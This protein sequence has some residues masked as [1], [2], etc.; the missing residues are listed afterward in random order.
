[1]DVEN[2]IKDIDY[3]CFMIA[4][5][6][7]LIIKFLKYLLSRENLKI[8]KSNS[9]FGSINSISPS[10]PPELNKNNLNT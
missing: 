10:S 6:I 8:K 2:I 9:L 5:F 7:F 4:I 3:I 1:M